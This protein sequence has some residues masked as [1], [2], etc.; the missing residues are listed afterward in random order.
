L[1]VGTELVTGQRSDTNG[2]EVARMLLTAGYAVVLR[3]VLPDDEGLVAETLRAV[4][5]QYELVVV[6]G[7]LG[8][9]HDDVTREAAAR[10]LDRVLIH[11]ADLEEGLSEVAARQRHD[12]AAAQILRQADVIEGAR[13]LLPQAGTAPGQ[14]LVTSRGHLLLL[15]G[16]PHELR[17]MLIETLSLL[18]LRETPPPRV[19]GCV[20]LPESDVQVLVQHALAAHKGVGFT[21][22]AKPAYVDVMLFAET[23]VA[24]Q[25][26]HAAEEIAGVLGDVCYAADGRSLAEVVVQL[27]V[28][29]D[30]RLALAESCT[31]GMIAAALTSVPGAS[32]VFVGGVVT[33]SNALKTQLLG[34]GKPTLQKCGAVCA[35][36]AAEMARGAK[37]RL[38]A[39]IA[40]AVTG[41]AGPG[42]G[43]PH[44]PVG[45][46]W[47]AVAT[48]RGVV[49]VHRLF[50]GDRHII[51]E[52]A[53][54][55]ALD[56]LRR[57]LLSHPVTH[58]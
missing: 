11:R 39:E 52:R 8:P 14:L 2:E 25:L 41:I 3:E 16:P 58:P 18:Q 35:E 12:D 53:T 37:E 15:P 6:T 48:E 44:K 24:T 1:L 50:S 21:V 27:A 33:Y 51:R 28:E 30:M 38:G 19:L 26:D 40:L 9:T 47:F 23:A 56:L 17:P 45:T 32:E 10:A 22:L 43:E 55:T 13:V 49:S 29:R 31:G 7:G 46:V 34:V 42:G 4:T 57:E 5:Q 54:A 36:T 20:G